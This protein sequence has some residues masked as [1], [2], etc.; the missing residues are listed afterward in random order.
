MF[1]RTAVLQNNSQCLLLKK[2]KINATRDIV[3]FGRWNANT[4]KKNTKEREK[5][6]KFEKKV[7]EKEWDFLIFI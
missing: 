6:G 4:K 1:Y 3:Q 7:K 2:K 5:K